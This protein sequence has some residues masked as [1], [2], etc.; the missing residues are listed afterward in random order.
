VEHFLFE[1]PVL[2]NGGLLALVPLVFIICNVALGFTISALVRNQ[3]QA[4][5]VTML[6]FLP[7]MLLSGFMFPFRGMPLWAQVIGGSVPITYFIRIAGGILLKGSNFGEIWTNFW[8]LLLFMLI[9]STAAI[10][11]YKKTLD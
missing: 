4:I 7:S 6:V 11:L 3:M 8:P 9:T 10:R 2:G 1:V 5:Q